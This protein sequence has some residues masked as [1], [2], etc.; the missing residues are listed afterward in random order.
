MKKKK[1]FTIVE[2]LTVMSIIVILFG[3][4]MP[5]ISL[6]KQY[7]RTV[8]QN[9]QFHSISAG[10]ELYYKTFEV[11]PPS[12]RYDG[13]RSGTFEYCGAMKLAEA[14]VGMDLL[15][16]HS[17][18]IFDRDGMNDSLPPPFDE[19]YPDPAPGTYGNPQEYM[20]NLEKREGPCIELEGANAYKLEDIYGQGNCDPFDPCNIVLCDEYPRA[21][22]I[23]SGRRIGMPILYYRADITKFGH[24]WQR[25]GQNELNI[26]NTNDNQDLID[27][28]LPWDI[29][30]D[31][32]LIATR[33]LFT[34][35]GRDTDPQIFYDMTE[36]KNVT[37][38]P[39]PYRSDSYILLSAGYD[40][41]YGTRDDVVNFRRIQ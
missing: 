39:R 24:E 33:G 38:V 29:D 23:R 6:V 15:G 30:G 31:D 25:G 41:I 13:D 26:Y 1:A 21:R 34:P 22:H 36:D 8:K 16:F 5:A 40:N 10:M 2:L 14:M 12:G 4:L 27:L 9:A 19:L 32:H 3:L 35:D 11:Y 28:G 18:S 7:A 20:K 17:D 37:A